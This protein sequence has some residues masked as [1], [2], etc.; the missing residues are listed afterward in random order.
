M[1]MEVIFVPR[2]S[3]ASEAGI[4]LTLVKPADSDIAPF[5]P[6]GNSRLE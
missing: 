5:L 1:I 3:M 4:V 6:H 2:F